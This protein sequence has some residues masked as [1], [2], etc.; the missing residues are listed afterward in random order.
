MNLPSRKGC[1][2][3]P[4]SISGSTRAPACHNRRP[5]DCAKG[6]TAGGDLPASRAQ[7]AENVRGGLPLAQASNY[8]PRGKWKGIDLLSCG[9]LVFLSTPAARHYHRPTNLNRHGKSFSLGIH[10]NNRSGSQRVRGQSRPRFTPR[11]PGGAKNCASL[12]H[13]DLR[14][15]ERT[16]R[17]PQAKG[18]L[19]PATCPNH[20]PSN[21]KPS[22]CCMRPGKNRTNTA[23]APTAAKARSSA[24]AGVQ[25]AS[26]NNQ[27]VSLRFFSAF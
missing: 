22:C 23:S 17:G 18:P 13:P 25:P 9:R 4:L 8:W 16:S 7:G 27:R 21:P 20:S 12:W 26:K 15:E 1:R 5:A 14:L 10:E 24:R 11:R 6:E 2:R 19:G 3:F